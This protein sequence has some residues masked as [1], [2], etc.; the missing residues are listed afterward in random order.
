MI[1]VSVSATFFLVQAYY[2]TSHTQTVDNVG[3]TM[4]VFGPT[5]LFC[6]LGS[7]NDTVFAL[8]FMAGLFLPSAAGFWCVIKMIG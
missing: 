6:A 8:A 7:P 1:A 4:V 3:Y 5:M 2:S